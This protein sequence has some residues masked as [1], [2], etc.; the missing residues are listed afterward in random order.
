VTGRRARGNWSR[1]PSRARHRETMCAGTPFVSGSVT[2][3]ARGRPFWRRW[4][5]VFACLL[6]L[7]LAP[8]LAHSQGADTVVVTW[9]APGDD[10][11]AGTA[12]SYDLRMSETP[13]TDAN[14]LSAAAVAGVPAPAASGTRQSVT[15]R[16]LTR[17]TT[18][19]FAIRATD[20]VG[21]VSPISNVLRWDWTLDTSP[22][23]TPRGGNG[24]RHDRVVQITWQANAEADLAG[25][26]VYRATASAGP[27]T[28]L[29]S[30]PIVE[31]QYEDAAV[32]DVPEVWYQVTAVDA[33]GNESARSG[34][35]AVELQTTAAESAIQPGYPNPS[36]ADDAVR[37]PVVLPSSGAASAVVDVLD[38]GGHRVRRIEITDL[39]P[40]R[41][42]VQWDGRNDAGRVVAPGVYRA[43]L[44]AGG[45]RSSIR[46]VRVP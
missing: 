19:W 10:G 16:S 1:R 18:Y 32:P 28:Q 43:W 6:L 9:T 15:V 38:S 41:Q 4:F 42:E 44:I 24:S 14:F 13:I 34:A 40:G 12:T 8:A 22:P 2:R 20:D 35:I 21:N 26:R 29:T 31:T 5:P 27:Y 46:L 33:T 30:A 23:S 25:Y 39:S 17:G 7:A 45:T 36:R 37:I 11:R 3:G